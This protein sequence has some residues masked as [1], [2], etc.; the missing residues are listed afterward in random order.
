MTTLEH[1]S[2]ASPLDSILF[3]D[4][5]HSFHFAQPL[6]SSGTSIP[7]FASHSTDTDVPTSA[8]LLS[9]S[10]SFWLSFWLSFS[11]RVFRS[12]PLA[13]TSSGAAPGSFP[14]RRS[15]PSSLDP[16]ASFVPRSQ[17]SSASTPPAWSRSYIQ[18]CRYVPASSR[19]S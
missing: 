5:T 14:G 15:V 11:F 8:V 1:T 16:R 4:S 9:L 17:P 19:E 10:L 3:R 7:P 12:L 18:Y 13:P 6:G 2:S